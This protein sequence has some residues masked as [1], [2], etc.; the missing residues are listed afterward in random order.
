MQADGIKSTTK[1]ACQVTATG[2]RNTIFIQSLSKLLV[3]LNGYRKSTAYF[4]HTTR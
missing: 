1:G 2:R 4:E 3:I